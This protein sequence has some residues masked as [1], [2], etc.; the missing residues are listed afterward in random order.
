MNETYF[1]A[2]V[3]YLYYITD[4]SS[5]G[6]SELRRAHLRCAE[7]T[8]GGLSNKPLKGLKKRKHPAVGTDFS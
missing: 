2:S 4:D 1:S 7:P 6:E 5:I 3:F 8:A